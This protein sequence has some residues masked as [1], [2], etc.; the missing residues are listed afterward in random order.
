M[1]RLVSTLHPE[2]EYLAAGFLLTA[3][4]IGWGFGCQWTGQWFPV[5]GLLFD[6][7]GAT[8]VL[9]PNHSGVFE[10]RFV[11]SIRRIQGGKVVPESQVYGIVSEMIEDVF[12][13]E[14][15]LPDKPPTEVYVGI[16]GANEFG[17]K[18]EPELMVSYKE[19]PERD[20]YYRLEPGPLYRE[21][22]RRGNQKND[23]VLQVGAILLIFGFGLQFLSALPFCLLSL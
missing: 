13:D 6:L 22:D 4:G 1:G 7:I 15:D 20:D 19:N 2:T 5:I 21:A 16:P 12:G 10:N 23:I 18:H 11:E 3:A 17:G 9:L 14:H 8:L